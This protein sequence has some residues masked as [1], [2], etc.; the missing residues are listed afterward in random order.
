[1]TSWPE[2]NASPDCRWCQLLLSTRD[3]SDVPD[4]LKVAVKIAE[5]KDHMITPRGAQ[6]LSVFLNDSSYV[7][8]VGYVYT[9]AGAF[10]S[11]RIC[12]PSLTRH[13]TKLILP[14]SILSPAVVCSL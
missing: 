8:L 13:L 1:M 10:D 14:Y 6:H 4:E 12:I 7:H 5:R 2:L 3:D 11:G 9:E